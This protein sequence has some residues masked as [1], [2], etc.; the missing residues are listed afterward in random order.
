MLAALQI[1]TVMLAAVALAP[2]LAHALEFPGKLRLSKE[3]YLTVQPIYY[4][5]FTIGGF[6]EIGALIALVLLLVFAPKGGAAYW[7]TAGAF[8]F[9]LVAHGTY[10]AVTHPVNKVWLK[11]AETSGAGSRFFSVGAAR[12]E[13]DGPPSWTALRDR[14]EQSHIARAGLFAAGLLLLTAA[15]VLTR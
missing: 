2:A 10:W 14:W 12:P 4:P 7:L 1:L 13:T 3:E 11:D 15:A 8:L 6:A 5:G 9:F